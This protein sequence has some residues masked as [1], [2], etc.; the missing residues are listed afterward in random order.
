MERNHNGFC[1]QPATKQRL[2][3]SSVQSILVVVDGLTKMVH[4]IPVTDKITVP[5]LYDALDKE[6]FSVHGLPDSILSDR[7][8]L[9]T[10]RYWKA[11]VR[12][13]TIDWRMSTAFRP[14][15]NSQ[16][17]RQNSTMEQYL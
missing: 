5:G 2:E 15:T 16:T 4:Y 13:V 9:I 1:R 7:D 3:W 8:S 12:Y 14:Q 6:V 11:L 17:K 10:S